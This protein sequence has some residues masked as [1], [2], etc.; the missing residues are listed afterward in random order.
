MECQCIYPAVY[1]V[2]SEVDRVFIVKHVLETDNM[3]EDSKI[4][5]GGSGFPAGHTS[6]KIVVQKREQADSGFNGEPVQLLRNLFEYF[7]LKSSR[8]SQ[9]DQEVDESKSIFDSIRGCAAFLDVLQ[10]FIYCKPIEGVPSTCMQ[11][12]AVERMLGV[13]SSSEILD[14]PDQD[15]PLLRLCNF[16]EDSSDCQG[17][18][19]RVNATRGDGSVVSRLLEVCV[20]LSRKVIRG[21]SLSRKHQNLLGDVNLSHTQ[22]PVSPL[23]LSTFLCFRH[24][25]VFTRVTWQIYFATSPDP[26]CYSSLWP[27]YK[28][29]TF[30]HNSEDLISCSHSLKNSGSIDSIV[31]CGEGFKQL[32]DTSAL[33]FWIGSTQ[34]YA[35]VSMSQMKERGQKRK[36]PVED[37]EEVL[38]IMAEASLKVSSR[39]KFGLTALE[40]PILADYEEQNEEQMDQM[41]QMQSQSRQTGKPFKKFRHNDKDEFRNR[42]YSASR[43][44]SKHV[45][46]FESTAPLLGGVKPST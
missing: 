40:L 27:R 31:G 20:S 1:L 16:F 22:W 30:D 17:L 10:K 32:L 43:P 9:D 29:I 38:T 42:A 4:T 11:N 37:A 39:I 44:P 46:E 24:H 12:I 28:A 35:L 36:E 8:S 15:H 33:Q 23:P 3:T 13:Q 25:L 14:D 34:S 26:L 6:W 21:L 41:E 7:T 18:L 2:L 19:Q 5:G 45:D